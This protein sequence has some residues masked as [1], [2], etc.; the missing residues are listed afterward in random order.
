MSIV[1]KIKN[2]IMSPK[3][4]AYLKY[5]EKDIQRN[6][7]LLEGTHGRNV[8]GHIYALALHLKTNSNY[9]VVVAIKKDA[10]IPN[11]LKENCVQHMSEKYLYYLATAEILINDTSFWTFFHKRKEQKYYIF[12]HGTPLKCLGKST[13]IQGYGNIQRNLAAADKIFVNNKFTRDKLAQDFGIEKIVHNEFVIGP[14]PRNSVLFDDSR[15]VKD[16]IVYMPT[17]RNNRRSNDIAEMR[18]Y[19]QLLDHQLDKGEVFVK[20][21]P[22]EADQLKIDELKL[23]RVKAFPSDIELYTFL[24]TAEKLITDYSSIMFDFAVTNR[25]IILFTYDQDKYEAER[26]LYFSVN[27]LPFKQVKTI[28]GLVK[29]LS[30]KNEINFRDVNKRFNPTDSEKGTIEITSF[31]LNNTKNSK[32][33]QLSNWN[34]KDNVLIYAY[35]FDNNGITNSL[36]NLLSKVDLTQRNYIITWPDGL[37]DNIREKVIQEFPAGVFTFIES[38]KTQAKFS[39]MF[40]TF[41][42]MAEL[43]SNRQIVEKMY[44]RDF[45]RIYP[46]LHVNS[47]IHYPGYDRSYAVWTWALQPLGINTMIFIHTDMEKEFKANKHLKRKIIYEAYQKANHV[48]CVTD[49]IATKIKREV[50]NAKITIMNVILNPERIISLAQNPFDKSIPEKLR[51]DFL[52]PDIKVLINVGRFSKQKGIDRLIKAFNQL[53]NGKKT[54]LVIVGSYGPEEDSLRKQINLSDR[55]EDIYFLSHLSSPYNL[56]KASDAFIFSSRYEGFGMVVFE[57]LALNTPVIMTDVPETVEALDGQKQTVLIV[58]NSTEGLVIGLEKFLSGEVPR[59]SFD[60]K[61]MLKESIEI[62]NTLF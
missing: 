53:T 21:H 47:F 54:K 39:E 58:E 49:S 14:S 12:W 32:I 48:I 29:A 44:Q 33:Q 23:K 17:W 16:R 59:P 10:K 22:Y 4:L 42:Y 62:W 41:A 24:A 40:Q 15:V 27:E 1:T 43:P 7:I 36:L 61:K 3:E 11:E 57:A 55:K 31:L 18:E 5:R 28:S 50:P 37:I 45:D 26:G 56:I 52:N 38:G 51:N 2:K 20:L 46:N 35:K 25:E 6:T 60:F 13:Q 9:K 34:G 8:E 30:E 19:L